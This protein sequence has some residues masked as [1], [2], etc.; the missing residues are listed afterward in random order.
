MDRASGAGV[1]YIINVATNLQGCLN[2]SRLSDSYGNVFTSFGIHPHHAGEVS[3]DDLD[4]VKGLFGASKKAIAIGEVGLDFY[5]DRSPRDIQKKLFLYFLELKNVLKL[6]III[7]SRGAWRDT[8]DMIKDVLGAPVDGVMH[9]FSQ[10]REYLSEALDLGFHISFAC[11]LT[12][13]S[14]RDLREVAGYVPLD[15]LLVETDA[16]FLAPQRFRGE[17]NEPAFIIH[18]VDAL[19]GVLKVSKNE[20]RTNTTN[21]AVKLFKLRP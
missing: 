21:N 16:P 2:G 8:I 18:L 13:P 1:K 17:K 10:G 5:K 11:N 19:A 7:H 6:P 9:C 4:K 3:K 14:A 15:R 12:Y 20:V